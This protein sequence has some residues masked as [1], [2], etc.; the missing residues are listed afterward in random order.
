MADL[1]YMHRAVQRADHKPIM[2]GMEL[3]CSS[4]AH[5]EMVWRF[6]HLNLARSPKLSFFG[7]PILVYI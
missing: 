7:V 6:G 3:G 1:V 2:N 4:K 5:E